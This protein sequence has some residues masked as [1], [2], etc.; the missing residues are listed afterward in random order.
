MCFLVNFKK[1]REKAL[2]Q[3]FNWVLNTSKPL[4]GIGKKI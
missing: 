2:L 4:T 3:V 1:N